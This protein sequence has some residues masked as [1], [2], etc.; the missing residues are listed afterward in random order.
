M[1][2]KPASN[3][4]ELVFIA[5]LVALFVLFCLLPIGLELARNYLAEVRAQRLLAHAKTL[6][7]HDGLPLTPSE[8]DRFVPNPPANQNAAPVYDQIMTIMTQHPK[9][10]ALQPGVYWAVFDWLAPSLPRTVFFYLS[11]R[12]ANNAL[13]LQT[14]QQYMQNTALLIPL[15]EKATSRP[16]CKFP[17][18]WRLSYS[19]TFPEY[20]MM[21]DLNTLLVLRAYLFN[22]QDKPLE[23]LHQIELGAKMSQHLGSD[24]VD[25]AF[26]MQS[27]L[28]TLLHYAWLRIVESH[29]NDPKVLA[30]AAKVS[31]MLE[32]PPNLNY[33]LAGSTLTT[34]LI[35]ELIKKEG[36]AR[37]LRALDPIG[38]TSSHPSG[39]SFDSFVT[40]VWNRLGERSP[41]ST[42][43]RS[44]AERMIGLELLYLHRLYQINRVYAKDPYR[45]YLAIHQLE[46]TTAQAAKKAPR[47][48]FLISFDAS[49]FSFDS[50]PNTS[51]SSNLLQLQTYRTQRQLLLYLLKY[52]L[53]NHQ[54][55]N[56]LQGLPL[57]E[58]IDPFTDRPMRYQKT[59][60]GGFIL[61]SPGARALNPSSAESE[62]VVRF[63]FQP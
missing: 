22:R 40:E 15:L 21:R 46:A 18:N 5:S 62:I 1:P 13:I 37:V 7:R 33:Y 4:R 51:F 2:T 32:P 9:W 41:S 29:P 59:H 42:F 49:P 6:I 60:Q 19:L 14:A 61:A 27:S 35:D 10:R 34:E 45:N 17:R 26:Q 55:P 57:N 23:A 28:D 44:Q 50:S 38:N 53:Q 11:N 63:P 36:P 54:F 56:N 12:P 39:D 30:Y 47:D 31:R 52:R 24:P 58:V 16:Y 20:Y 8:M 48:Y 3:R 25:I 43:T